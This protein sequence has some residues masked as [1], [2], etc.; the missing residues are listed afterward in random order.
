MPELLALLA[1]FCF[2]LAATLQQKGALGVGGPEVAGGRGFL[3]LVTRGW[4]LVGTLVLLFGYAFQAVA[5]NEG[6]LAIV[7]S[8]LVTTIVFALPLGRWLTDQQVNRSEILAAGAIV[9]GLAVFTYFG[10]EGAGRSTA[11]T[12]QWALT[13]LV[14]GSLA[15]GFVIVGRRSDQGRKA[16]YLGAAAGVLYALS[17]AMWK[18][19]SEAWSAGG[20]SGLLTS[21]E[22]YAWAGAALVA[23]VFQQVSL[24]LGHLASTVAT[25]SV[26]NPIVSVIIGI[27]ILQERLA[28]P[29]WHKV[30]AFAGLGVALVAA[31]RIT[32]ATEG[33]DPGPSAEDRPPSGALS[34]GAE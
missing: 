28:D 32:Q 1:A 20:L 11:P 2:A 26:G 7:Q 31:I 10:D 15:A 19:T 21:W 23:F 9:L 33:P 14:F 34:A 22:F 24:A 18:P 13:F 30:V 6:Q 5:L 8:L 4:W 3:R 16:A 12:W 27:L 25:V 17:A 29:T